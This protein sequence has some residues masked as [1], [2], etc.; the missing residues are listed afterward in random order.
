MKLKKWVQGVLVTL[1]VVSSILVIT[2]IE[3]ELSLGFILFLILNLS[4]ISGTGL[5]LAKF[6]RWQ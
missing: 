6:G 4:V 3:S 1:F 5:V 2:T